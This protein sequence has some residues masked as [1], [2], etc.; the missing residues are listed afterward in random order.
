M[1]NDH[2]FW[3]INKWNYYLLPEGAK[4]DPPTRWTG[5]LVTAAESWWMHVASVTLKVF[6]ALDLPLIKKFTSSVWLNDNEVHTHSILQKCINFYHWI[7][8]KTSPKPADVTSLWSA[9]QSSLKFY[10]VVEGW[11]FLWILNLLCLWFSGSFKPESQQRCFRVEVVRGVGTYS[12]PISDHL[13]KLIWYL[14][15]F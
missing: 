5:D 6:E 9:N 15:K 8:T 10:L 7:N 11:D 2:R 14:L 13:S 1:S 3:H 12:K 4:W